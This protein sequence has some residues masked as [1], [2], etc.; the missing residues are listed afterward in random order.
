MFALLGLVLLLAGVARLAWVWAEQGS[1]AANSEASILAAVLTAAGLAATLARWAIRKRAAAAQPATAAQVSQAAAT[2]AELVREQWTNEVQ[3]RALG[4]PEPIPVR[5]RLT[6]SDIMDHPTVIN[7]DGP[8][9]FAGRSDQ[10]SG[11]AAA[12]R[13]L[14]HR[15]LVITGGPGTGKTTLAVQLLLALLPP[16]DTAPSEPVP[17]LFSLIG[18]DPT[19]QPRLQDWLTAQLDQTYPALHAIAPGAPAALVTRSRVLPILDGLDEI[20]DTRRP[21][22]IAALN[23]ILPA[24]LIPY[25]GCGVKGRWRGAGTARPPTPQRRFASLR[26]RLRRSL[27]RGSLPGLGR[28]KVR[29][30]RWP[31]PLDAPRHLGFRPGV[32]GLCGSRAGCGAGKVASSVGPLGV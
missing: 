13:A 12:F 8:L 32:A 18:W 3:A 14:P 4:E 29:A 30:G 15:R 10:I 24:G 27:T 21:T 6:T 17:V 11:L 20:A 7:P 28:G 9:A 5:W 31:C 1:S 19:T 22:V 26:D 2:L 23:A 25:G 16:P